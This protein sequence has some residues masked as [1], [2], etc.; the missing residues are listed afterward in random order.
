MLKWTK[1]LFRE[2]FLEIRGNGILIIRIYFY[3][4]GWLESRRRININQ[5][6]KNKVLEKSLIKIL[7]EVIKFCLSILLSIFIYYNFAHK[8]VREDI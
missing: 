1:E 3:H 6:D 8:I 4:L 7:R 5:Y 2:I